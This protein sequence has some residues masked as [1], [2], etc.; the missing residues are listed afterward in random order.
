VTAQRNIPVA[1]RRLHPRIVRAAPLQY[2][3]RKYSQPNFAESA[4][5]KI[6][7][8]VNP[9]HAL[10]FASMPPPLPEVDVD[11]D[12]EG[13]GNSSHERSLLE[14]AEAH[15]VEA[16]QELDVRYVAAQTHAWMQP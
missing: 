10:A 2:Y 8:S 16:S 14:E 13:Q 11:E 15:A 5:A 7:M 4:A 1:A 6:S 3:H 12:C 9:A